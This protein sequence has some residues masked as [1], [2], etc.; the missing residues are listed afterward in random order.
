MAL[1]KWRYEVYQFR[2][3]DAKCLG[4]DVLRK[5]KKDIAKRI[6]QRAR[7]HKLNFALV[8]WRRETEEDRENE[9]HAHAIEAMSGRIWKQM[10]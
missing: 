6:C 9:E 10:V 1:S 4:M 5:T 3:E 2:I 8:K 7:K